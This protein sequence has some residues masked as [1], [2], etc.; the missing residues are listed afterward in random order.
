MGI[1]FNTGEVPQAAKL[2][3]LSILFGLFLAYEIGIVD[4]LLGS[5]PRWSPK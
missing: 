2:E 1:F 5:N 4:G 3:P